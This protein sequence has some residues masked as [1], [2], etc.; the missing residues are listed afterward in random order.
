VTLA[1]VIYDN[2]LEVGPP[3][4]TEAEHAFAR[5]MQKNAQIPQTGLSTEIL[6]F[7]P[8]DG[9]ITDTSEFSW[10][11]PY[12]ALNITTAPTQSWHNWMVTGCAGNSIGKKAID[13]VASIL[14]GTALQVLTQPELLAKAKK[15]WQQRTEGQVY[16]SLLPEGHQV[17]LGT[18]ASIMDQYFPNRWRG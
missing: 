14:S 9:P 7:G 2:L 13:T 16:E 18:N 11:A 1:R 12:A 15:E 10:W 3:K 17:P 8:D 6:P 4:F 5:E